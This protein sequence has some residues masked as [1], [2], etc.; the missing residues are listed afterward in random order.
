VRAAAIDTL[1]TEAM[2]PPVAIFVERFG[3]RD[4]AVRK[5][6]AKAVAQLG[7]GGSSAPLIDL[8]SH[9]PSWA[10]RAE[11]ARGVGAMKSRDAIVPLSR[12]LTSRDSDLADTAAA[13]L[14]SIGAPAVPALRA[15]L[16]HRDADVREL[17]AQ[18]LG[19]IGS[20]S[21]VDELI[22]SLSDKEPL[23]RAAA[24]TALGQIGEPAAKPL[25][26]AAQKAGSPRRDAA[27]WAL[28]FLEGRARPAVR[29]G[30]PDPGGVASRLRNYYRQSGMAP[31]YIQTTTICGVRYCLEAYTWPEL[32]GAGLPERREDDG[33][34]PAVQ[35]LNR[36][37]RFE[38]TLEIDAD[39]RV[40]AVTFDDERLAD[41][42]VAAAL[43][44]WTFGRF[45]PGQVFPIQHRVSLTF[46]TQGRPRIF[47]SRSFVEFGLD[48]VAVVAPPL[49]SQT[50]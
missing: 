17:A 40:S 31:A 28:R 45:A 7:G 47:R 48:H 1:V 35:D 44:S 26:A 20:P 6:A 21:A 43:R 3:D 25:L 18:S 39:G 16:H 41:T 15:S 11:A 29:E 19:G 42:S 46:S 2:P 12:N 5:A 10:V 23:V 24:A 14:Q 22:A 9:D 4:P 37:R 36:V 32:P 49:P 33:V 50:N 30:A 27:V 38:A 8:L 34:R 13:A